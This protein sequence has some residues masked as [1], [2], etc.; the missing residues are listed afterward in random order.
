VAGPYSPVV[1]AGDWLVLSGQLGLGA[2]GRLVEGGTEPEA[3]Q[4]L[5]NIAGVLADC[6]ASWAHV[7]KIGIFLVDLGQFPAVNALYE[8][9]LGGHRP[10]R[11]T[12]GVRALP[13]GASIEIECWV[14]APATDG[15]A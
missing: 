1:R 15:A 9:A 11:T 7:A 14:H 2:D 12:V 4:A 6:G 8:H 5:A 13:A 10:A 3:R